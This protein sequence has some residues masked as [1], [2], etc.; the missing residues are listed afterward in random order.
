MTGCVALGLTLPA[1]LCQAAVPE[2]GVWTTAAALAGQFGASSDTRRAADDLLR[3]A[4]KAIKDGDLAKA[5]GLIGQAEKLGVKYDPLTARFVDTPDKLRKLL[6]E[7][8]SRGPA[9]QLPSSRFPALGG[10]QPSGVPA[11]PLASFNRTNTVEQLTGDAKPKALS[12][13]KDAR[14]ALSAGD[15]LA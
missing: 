7:A 6:D 1:T 13:L 8:K 15:K 4:R 5:D 14:A 11:D 3:Q 2:A 12:L 9:A 10:A